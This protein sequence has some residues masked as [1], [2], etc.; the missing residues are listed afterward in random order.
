MNLREFA[1]Q[2]A[3]GECC[4]LVVPS[5]RLTA[6][7]FTKLLKADGLDLWRFG[8]CSGRVPW[9]SK[10]KL[11]PRLLVAG[12]ALPDLAKI[13][14]RAKLCGVELRML[15]NQGVNPCAS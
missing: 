4:F 11:V 7:G 5:R 12:C 10:V 1:A 15:T 13:E 8:F 9:G 2:A 3:E 14:R 6:G